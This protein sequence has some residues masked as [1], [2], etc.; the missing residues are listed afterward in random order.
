MS[1]SITTSYNLHLVTL[2]TVWKFRNFLAPFYVKISFGKCSLISSLHFDMYIGIT[3][4]YLGRYSPSVALRAP[5]WLGNNVRPKGRLRYHLGTF[6][7]LK[8]QELNFEGHTHRHTKC[9]LVIRLEA[10]KIFHFYISIGTQFSVLVK[11]S[12]VWNCNAVR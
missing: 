11:I 5:R 1:R 6:G 7:G 9:K 4:W 12:A 3:F 2:G 10:L 8:Y